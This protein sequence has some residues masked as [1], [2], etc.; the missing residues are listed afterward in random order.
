MSKPSKVPSLWGDTLVQF[1]LALHN[2]DVI[3][4]PTIAGEEPPF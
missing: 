1:I 3:W 2:V 4:K